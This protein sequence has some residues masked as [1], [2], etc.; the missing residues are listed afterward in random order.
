MEQFAPVWHSSIT[1]DNSS[2]LERIQKSDKF[3]GYKEGLA[4]L[5]TETLEDRRR[6]LYINFATKCVKDEKLGHMFPKNEKFHM[7]KT[8]NIESYKVYHA[9]TDRIKNSPIIYMQNLLNQ[10]LKISE[11]FSELGDPE[12]PFRLDSIRLF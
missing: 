9:N 12:Q 11:N 6:K 3:N 4:Q 10:E 8:R 1:S 5:G 2:D 7:M